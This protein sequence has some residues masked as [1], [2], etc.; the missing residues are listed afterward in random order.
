MRVTRLDEAWRLV[1]RAGWFIDARLNEFRHGWCSFSVRKTLRTL[2]IY[3]RW[4]SLIV[5]QTRA[6]KV[7]LTN[8]AWEKDR[9]SVRPSTGPLRTLPNRDFW[10]TKIA[11]ELF[12]WAAESTRWWLKSLPK[13]WEANLH[14]N[15][16]LTERRP[17]RLLLGDAVAWSLTNSSKFRIQIRAI[18]RLAFTWQAPLPLSS[19]VFKYSKF[20]IALGF[21]S[22]ASKVAVGPTA[23]ANG[24]WTT[25]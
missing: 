3:L 22:P 19:A 14:F 17:V 6:N 13:I 16:L 9:L 1:V 12:K 2:D 15:L 5:Y 8:R 18:R 4:S 23:S 25:L 20:L 11:P 24:N 21:V 7:C 10:S